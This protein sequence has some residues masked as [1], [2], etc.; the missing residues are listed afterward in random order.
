[1]KKSFCEKM[2]IEA[3][4]IR[5][6][7]NGERLENNQS[8]K[9]LNLNANDVIEVFREIS[10]GGPPQRK[11]KTFDVEQ[12]REA[13]NK[14]SDYDESED[15]NA[16]EL[17]LD[18]AKNGQEISKPETVDNDKMGDLLTE[19]SDD[20]NQPKDSTK[21]EET[22][23]PG[24][25]KECHTN[26]K[27]NLEETSQENVMMNPNDMD[28]VKDDDKKELKTNQTIV[29]DSFETELQE[30]EKSDSLA[31]NWLDDL[32]RKVSNETL[33]ENSSIHK[34]LKFYLGLPDLTL[35]EMNI[36]KSLSERLEIHADWKLEKSSL[37]PK[38]KRILKKR[39]RTEVTETSSRC[40]RR[41]VGTQLENENEENSESNKDLSE[42]DGTNSNPVNTGDGSSN[43]PKQR[44]TLFQ[45][46]GIVSPFFRQ[47]VP[48]EEELRRLSLA[49]H[50]WAE[51]TH[52]SVSFL[53]ENQL[54][55]RHFRDILMFAGPSSRWKLIPDRS[56]T[57][58]KNIWQNAHNGTEH[59]HG[60][61][62]T[63]FE[64]RG[65]L[66]D[67]SVRFCPFGHCMLDSNLIKL[68]DCK[69]SKGPTRRKL[70][71]PE[72]DSR[73]PLDFDQI[74]VKQ[75]PTK[76]ELKQKNNFLQHQI[77]SLKHQ[78]KLPQKPLEPDNKDDPS[79][80]QP[81]IVKCTQ[82]GCTKAFVTVFGL[83][84]H[85]KKRH[86]EI[87]DFKKPKQECPFCGKQTVYIDQHIKS[88][89]KEM[90]GN[91][92]CEVC[93]QRIKQDMKKHRSVCIFCPFCGYQN[94]KKDRLLRHIEANHKE[95]LLQDAP[96][97]L[98]SPR[99]ES[100]HSRV[101][102]K[103][104][105]KEIV[106][107][108][109]QA[110]ALDL[111][112]PT[113]DD[114]ERPLDLSP[115]NKIINTAASENLP[116]ATS[117]EADSLDQSESENIILNHDS[118]NIRRE[119]TKKMSSPVQS[120][121]GNLSQKISWEKKR[122]KY[123]FDNADEPYFSELEDG[124]DESFTQNRRQIK[125]ALEKELRQ[126]DK[127]EAKELEGDIEVLEQFETFMRN[128]TNRNQESGEYQ[129]EVSTVRMYTG[130]LRND[131]LPAFHQLF[132]PFDSRWLLDCT[133]EKNCKFDGE[134]RFYLK[135]EEP[136]Y[137]TSKII[138]KALDN[139]TE[140]GGQQG[141]QRGTILNAAVQLMNFIEIYFNQRLNVYGRG[142]YESVLMYHQG[143]KTF[144][145]GTGSW[146]RCNDE[147]DRAQNE[148]KMRQSYLHPNKD[149]EVLQRYKTYINS[150]DR[151]KNL[152]K[153][154]IHS[155][156]EEKRPT[157]R[158]MPELGKIAM[159][160][161]VAATG[162]RPVVLLKLT[163]EAWV[164]KKPG[165]NPYKV[166]NDDCVVDEE[167][168]KDKIYRR[169]DPNLPPKDRACVHQIQENVAECPIMC[170]ERCEPDGYN[171]LITW[172]KTSGC[173]GPSYLHIPKELKHMM[174][175][176]DI[177]RIRYFKGRKPNPSAK[178]DWFHEDSTPFFLNS[179]CSAFK[180][181]DLKH[182]TECMG[183][184]VTAYS[185]RKIVA[186]WAC[187]H[188][189]EEIRSCEEE[190]LQ[191]S[192]KIAKDKYM[193]NKMVKPQRLVQQYA[194]DES[195]FPEAFRDQIEKSKSKVKSAIKTTEEQR[196]KKRIETLNKRK[197]DYKKLKSDKRPLG[198]MH[199]ILGTQRKEFL[200]LIK[201]VKEIET[202]NYLEN[203][204]PLQWRQLVVRTICTA[205]E[206]K[207]ERLR[208]LWMEMYQG[209][210][211]W[212]VR[213]A[214]LKAQERNWPMG[215]I[216]S[217]RDRNSWIA[218]CLRK[219][220]MSKVIRAKKDSRSKESE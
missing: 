51:R 202:E 181:L 60:D 17:A 87:E 45:M 196:T 141:G 111:T 78:K 110:E 107:D 6:F 184:D 213:D 63:G 169:I 67:P 91:D 215:Q 217:R 26:E 84:Q 164:D 30:E 136:I 218:G 214:R 205:K 211:K 56:V 99:K 210:L 159:G 219:S 36:V 34:Q 192:L 154:L 39:K 149:A 61:L 117:E 105:N 1:M 195:L 121:P 185:F 139:S 14:S 118:E 183:I 119:V 53:Q 41:K 204:K 175:I 132:E 10:G 20:L 16:K 27:I 166:S 97:D 153:I 172:D 147:K 144:I 124:D 75:S 212:G 70:F 191:H 108:A 155:E 133:T 179:A 47:K 96:L 131:I 44:K 3:S 46:F 65:K 120:D 174:D 82:T 52:G 101:Q 193:Q 31:G 11:N 23:N 145:S 197:E 199:R 137:I 160:E 9:G 190:A 209:D 18:K 50:L 220:H 59:F 92:T 54:N 25:S 86:G 123:P 187:S 130:A 76:E 177:K 69:A 127:L 24:H 203:L 207:G 8:I 148:N 79:F 80:G 186:T 21:D 112:S 176:Y 12:I 128:K 140:K 135:P 37:F 113:K 194:E 161:L 72:K 125:D 143:V 38:K 100:D 206:K 48:S 109:T 58:Y 2:S 73:Q 68:T 104:K 122:S 90:K 88:L 216:T 7:C 134:Q 33:P 178:D 89:H 171:I 94:R 163:V 5:I 106:E 35:T 85:L 95:N 157:D 49:V 167:D 208:K 142:P 173:K 42:N 29:Q 200:G 151:I 126:I 116:G 4:T 189:S 115:P 74:K 22:V 182:V 64:T 170:E 165:F 28:L 146:K 201:E 162:C 156:N 98:T 180:S 81:K 93:K 188:A 40:L 198:P 71:T 103:R 55:E 83:E 77:N 138:Q 19:E 66:H 114:Q 13:L 152:N 57:Q 158:E 43:T 168:G 62:E 102:T 129:S 15:T 150:S 32:R